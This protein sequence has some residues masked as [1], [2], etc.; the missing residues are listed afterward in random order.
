[1]VLDSLQN[2][3]NLVSGAT[4]ASRARAAA[5]AHGLLAQAGLDDA[6]TDAQDRISKLA[7]DIVNAS[8]A[9]REMLQNLISAEVEKAATKLGFARGEQ[10][11]D[12]EAQIVE[13]RLRVE[14]LAS[15]TVAAPP[16]PRATKTPATKPPATKPPA[17]KTPATKAAGNPSTARTQTTKTSPAAKAAARKSP[18]TKA[19]ARQ[20]PATTA[21]KRTSP[22]E[23][24]AKRAVARPGPI[25]S[26]GDL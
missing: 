2:Y 14:E 21:A 25:D 10:V 24:A 16:R 1:M 13:L 12:L 19:A 17:T 5:A 7:D 8:R 3:V 4:K 18:A 23:R 22:A 6:A 15:T 20:S 26:S 9:N 11:E